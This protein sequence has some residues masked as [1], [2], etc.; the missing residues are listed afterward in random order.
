MSRAGNG[1]GPATT[2]LPLTNSVPVS[3]LNVS[4]VR[5]T[6]RV[7]VTTIRPGFLTVVGIGTASGEP[8]NGNQ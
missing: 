3:P 2:L 6:V 4:R 7:D 1:A 8:A 5:M